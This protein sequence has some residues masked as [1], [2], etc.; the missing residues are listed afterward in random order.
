M[1]KSYQGAD[2]GR[3]EA[4]F[5]RWG[6]STT[7]MHPGPIRLVGMVAYDLV[8]IDDFLQL[9]LS[10]TQRFFLDACRSRRLIEVEFQFADFQSCRKTLRFYCSG[11]RA[12]AEFAAR[13]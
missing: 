11:R 8:G 2:R 7:L 1:A 3:E 10:A 13:D 9:D 5:S 12:S 6:S 4:I